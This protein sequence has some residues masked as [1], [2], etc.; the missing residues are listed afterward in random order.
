MGGMIS[1]H[2][3]DEMVAV[4]GFPEAHEDD[5][6]RAVHAGLDLVA[7]VGQLLSPA[8]QPLQMRIGIATSL[9]LVG[10]GQAIIGEA[11]GVAAGLRHLASP[12]AI[13]V[14]ESTRKL[15]S[16]VF[17]CEN[18]ER[19]R[20]GGDSE[21]VNACRVTGRRMVESRFKA[22]R[23]DEIRRLVGRDRELQ[24]LS[25]L[26]DRAK[27]GEGQVALVC[28]EPGI[29]K[30]HLCEAFMAR[31]AE[32]PHVTIRYQCS[33]HHCNSPFYPVINQLEQAI[34]F[35]HTDTPEN[36]ITKIEAALSQAVKSTR[37]DISL[38]ADLLSIAPAKLEPTSGPTPKRSK[39]LII[40]ALTRHLL[41]IAS[42]Q[43][44]II[45]LADAHWIDSSTLELID[46]II[47]SIK[48]TRILIIIKFRPEFCPQWLSKSHVTMLRLDRLQREET[49]AIISDLTGGKELPSE[50][51]EQIIRKTD[52]IPLYVEELTKTVL[53]SELVEDLGDRY[54]AP[55]LLPPLAIPATL[56]ESLSARLVQLG[57]A[58]RIAQIG[59]AIGREFSYPLLAAVALETAK[60]LQ[61]ALTQLV[62]SELISA[63]GEPPDT[64][65]TFKHALVQDSAYSM[66]SRRMRQ[67]LHGRIADAL[68]KSFPHIIES[69]PELLAHH[70]EQAGLIERA[71][72]YLRK[73]GQRAIETSAHTEAIRHLTHAL[74]L[75]RLLPADT[76]NMH[77]ELE[78]NV[79]LTQAMIAGRGYA[80]SET[81]RVLSRTKMLINS[82]TNPS[83][84]LA[85]L[86]ATWASQYVAAELDKQ[87]SSAAELLAEAES[88]NDRAA[89]CVAY[90]LLGTTCVTRG[91]FNSGLRHLQRAYAFF[92]PE[93]DSR[94]QILYGQDS[95]AAAL[96]YLSW[97]LWHL[98]YVDQASKIA[99]K[100]MQRAEGLCHPHT[101]VYT[102]C[103]ARGFMDIFSRRSENLQSCAGVIASVCEE[104]GLWHWRNCGRI[105]EGW[106]AVCRGDVEQGIELLRAG[107][108][109]WQKAGARLWMPIF[110]SMEAEAYAKAGRSDAALHAINRALAISE[111]TG[112]RWAIAEMLRL[113][114]CMLSA[115]GA[116]A[117][118]LETLL[119]RSLTA[120][121][122]QRARCSE[123]R[124]SWDLARLWEGQGR[125]KDAIRLLQS[126]YARFSEGFDTMDLRQAK[127]LM[128]SMLAEPYDAPLPVCANSDLAVF[129]PHE[130]LNSP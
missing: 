63:C 81:K 119:S 31:I 42:Q 7:K 95:G 51:Q 64:T 96:C 107:I 61:A 58:R 106:D 72:N 93:H 23:P 115:A 14:A 84:K 2:S 22:S 60:S 24:Q 82:S 111:E 100:A 6:E 39:H 44:L 77:V 97:A 73:A 91:R 122:R 53:E 125:V 40:A 68:E 25:A 19:H 21:A 83:Q 4:F 50:V 28:G 74:E 101:L 118:Q 67:P 80:A 92:D 45:T 17:V 121:R 59:A 37:K 20:L 89:L 99:D 113:K 129:K 8:N 38:Y 88:R 66:L 10:Q 98:G 16:D 87:W 85:I 128:E 90:R 104:H 36:N 56:L 3:A 34:K 15:L 11:L 47:Q 114:A 43:P 110:H 18:L 35:E 94:S 69:Q 41:D 103:H 48:S 126:I 127:G 49:C 130:A 62:T 27:C 117:D 9:V 105:L 5:A 52:G 109:G 12:N 54:V 70:L 78:L 29:G 46:R 32:E 108:A 75:L 116:N 79:M 57:P 112:E 55:V 30:S 86:Y 120:A 76:D 13:L 123:L 33:P 102:L 71:I 1:T 124:A 65:Y 26:W